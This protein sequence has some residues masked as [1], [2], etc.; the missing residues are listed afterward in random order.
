MTLI[1][2]VIA[3]PGSRELSD[4]VLL[5]CGWTRREEPLTVLDGV[6]QAVAIIW[7]DT[8]GR[9]VF[10]APSPTESIDDA[11]RL[12]PDGWFWRVGRSTLYAGWAHLNR[13]HP[14]HCDEGDEFSANAASPPLA[15]T[16]AALRARMEG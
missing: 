6:P 12:V 4:E 1:E 13:K 8:D 3:G 14:N 11:L 10:E 7:A 9:R 2:R 16:A 15:L 5:A